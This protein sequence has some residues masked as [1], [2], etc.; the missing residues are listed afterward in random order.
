MP[1]TPDHSA[2]DVQ[3]GERLRAARLKAGLTQADLGAAMGVVFQQVQK[4]ERGSNRLSVSM[5]LAAAE[6]TATPLADF[7]PGAAAASSRGLEAR[8]D[9]VRGGAD[10]ARY[11]R[12][13][14]P[15]DRTILVKIAERF[16]RG[17]SVD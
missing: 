4:Y 9:S 14:A 8:I 10:L 16:A 5:L 15:A 13:M 7:L 6:A 11:F 17:R 3:I 1:R 2:T 12:A